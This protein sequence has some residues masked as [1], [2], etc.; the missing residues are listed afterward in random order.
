M[1]GKND[2]AAERTLDDV[3]RQLQ[4]NKKRNRS[5]ALLIG[6]GCS[7]QAGIPLARGFIDEIQNRFP[8]EYARAPEKTYPHCMGELSAADR[9]DLISEFIDQAKVNWAH[10]SIGQLMKGGFIDRV[11]TTNFDPMV[12]RACA[13]LNLFPAVYDMAVV[14]EGFLADFVRDL[15]V[16]HLHGQR[17]GFVQLH[18]ENEV[19]ALSKAIKPLF[20]DTTYDR[21]WLVIGYSGSNDPVFRVLADRPGFPNRLFWVGYRDETPSPA[22]TAA[23]LDANKDAYWIPGHDPDN[24]LVQLAAKL[25]CFPPGFFAKPFSH[26]L[27]G[28]ASLAGFRLPGQEVELDWA[29]RARG[30]IR[31]AIARFEETVVAPP[32]APATPGLRLRPLQ[33]RV[34]VKRIDGEDTTGGGIIIPD[35]AKERP[36]EGEIRIAV[37]PAAPPPQAAPSPSGPFGIATTRT[38][39]DDYAAGALEAAG[40]E[41]A[42]EA[43]TASGV[44]DIVGEAWIALIAG[45]YDKVIALGGG[46]ILGEHAELAEPTAGAYFGRGKALTQ[47]ARGKTGNEADQLFREATDNYARALAIKPDDHAS[48]SNWGNALYR[49]ARQKEANEAEPLLAEAEKKLLQAEAIHPGVGAY[50][51]SRLAAFRG[52]EE[53]CRHWLGI[54]RTQGM[55]PSRDFL[56]SDPDLAAMRGAPWFRSFIE[57]L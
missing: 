27:E 31:D 42:F 10:I 1:R 18:R 20:D 14:R 3:A 49:W 50:R 44:T 47:L 12:M 57:A 30:W 32:A 33:D 15:A 22:V 34:I 36:Q 53:D 38:N 26:L 2:M 21:T 39:I 23:L 6:A 41:S 19:E 51:L 13:L 17:D 40:L 8:D 52:R 5:C 56:E 24:F 7:V 45:D 28:Y 43:T 54:A 4:G 25:G 37:A 11:L 29:A 9:H 55:L 48:L 16:F 46:D 35:S